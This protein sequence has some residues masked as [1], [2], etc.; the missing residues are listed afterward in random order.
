MYQVATV[1]LL[2]DLLY[3]QDQDSC[4]NIQEICYSSNR[5][6][7]ID[8]VYTWVNGSDPSL[9]QSIEYYKRLYSNPSYG[10]SNETTEIA[11]KLKI[12]TGRSLLSVRDQIKANSADSNVVDN[13]FEVPKECPI[14]GCIAS[15]A[16]VS[17]SYLPSSTFTIEQIRQFVG[18]ANTLEVKY[19]KPENAEESTLLFIKF[20]SVSDAKLAAGRIITQ[21]SLTV[22]F[23]PVYYT[24]QHGKGPYVKTSSK[25][26][27]ISICKLEKPSE[28]PGVLSYDETENLLCVEKD[29]FPN[30]QQNCRGILDRETFLVWPPW[31]KYMIG[32]L[33]IQDV[34][35]HRFADNEELR[36]S[37][38]SV[39]K[40]APWVR[41]IYILTNGQIPN[42]LNV[43]HDRIKIVTHSEVFQ[44]KSHLPTFSSPS[45]ES[46]M[47]N[48]PGISEHFLYFN[49][50]VFLGRAVYP[51][52]FI[53]T[54][55]YKVFLAWN[56]PNC[57]TGCPANWL[58][59]GYCDLACNVSACNF[60]GGDCQ[61]G[62]PAVARLANNIINAVPGAASFAQNYCNPGCSQ[63]W[64][65]DK[66]CDPACNVNKCGFDA[67]DCGIKDIKSELFEMVLKSITNNTNIDVP[68]GVSA[69]YFN[70][71]LDNGTVDTASFESDDEA[72]VRTSILSLPHKIVSLTVFPNKT[73]SISVTFTFSNHSSKIIGLNVNSSLSAEPF[74]KVENSVDTDTE[75][76]VRQEQW[77]IPIMTALE[78]NKEYSGFI[79]NI[80]DTV[81]NK[82]LSE[83]AQS[84]DNSLVELVKSGL[85]TEKGRWVKLGKFIAS[86]RSEETEGINQRELKAIEMMPKRH[87]LDTFADSIHH[88][89]N[90]YTSKFGKAPRKVLSHMPFLVNKTIL[91]DLQSR[92]VKTFDRKVNRSGLIK[93]QTTSRHLVPKIN[94]ICLVFFNI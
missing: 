40:F 82:D 93:L 60:D 9:R 26:T 36:Y 42:W 48:I 43:Q 54:E 58:T 13:P 14:E 76:Q 23:R 52:D 6:L 21:G 3:L 89:N 77:E 2:I 25:L 84:Y 45:I 46:N 22:K 74:V 49:D 31:E 73:G 16:V 63:S 71:S 81:D 55:G 7:P 19:A 8:V 1:I 51:E 30:I 83:T 41:N 64:V 62:S 35:A 38:R 66:Y 44:N 75:N 79:N 39:Y 57:N 28:L 72:L 91:G 37:L 88:V 61:L 92:L 70:V 65:G 47:K 85:L 15:P 94:I 50:D 34:G 78:I 87:L 11:K 86:E 67:G 32:Q 53:S 5:H 59:D 80:M 27:D 18:F 20:P 24:F 4:D 56:I 69:M 68:A 90:I 33:S 29:E 10:K 12:F 17:S